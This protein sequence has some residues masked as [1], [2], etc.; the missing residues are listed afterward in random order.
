MN[1]KTYLENDIFVAGIVMRDPTEPEDCNTALH[2]GGDADS[3][4]EN[5]RKLAA[6]LDCRLEDFVCASQSHSA[7][8]H[9]VA[10]GDRGRGS[11]STDDAIPDTDALYTYEPGL[12][13]CC[14]TAD[15][16]PV[17]FYHG[18]SGL[19]G[20][21]HS[22]WGGTVKEIAPKLLGHLKKAEHCDMSDMRVTIG[23]AISQAKFE[24]GKDV[25]DQYKAL[26]YGNEFISYNEL[27]HKYHIDNQMVVKRQCELQGVPGENISVDRTCTY[28]STDG[29]SFRQDRN[30]G[31]H[32]SFIMKRKGI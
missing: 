14:F 23:P 3:I 15:C 28:V 31:R 27:T 13:L 25:Y 32:L 5:R 11:V 1:V 10:L 20:M 4:I 7:N 19:I 12:L 24:V 6:L 26:G 2:T 9:K 16:V 30:T 8:F 21:I 29:F 18:E 22:G 17:I